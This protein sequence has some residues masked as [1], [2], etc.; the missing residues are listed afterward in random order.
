MDVNDATAK[1]FKEFAAYWKVAERIIERSSKEEIANVAR[2][3]ALHA[4]AYARRFGDLPAQDQLDYFSARAGEFDAEQLLKTPD[5]E[6]LVGL[7]KDGMAALVGV[8]ATMTEGIGEEAERPM[9]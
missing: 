8:L 3:L 9:Q 7:L 2:I 4:A 6:R 1:D 5:G